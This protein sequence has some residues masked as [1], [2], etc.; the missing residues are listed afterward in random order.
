MGRRP[1]HPTQPRPDDEPSFPPQ[2]KGSLRGDEIHC[3]DGRLRGSLQPTALEGRGRSVDRHDL[4]EVKAHS[5]PTGLSD[6]QPLGDLV[7]TMI[8]LIVG[9]PDV[10][11]LCSHEKD[12]DVFSWNTGRIREVFGDVFRSHPDVVDF[13]REEMAFANSKIK[14]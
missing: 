2:I 10:E 11:F 5:L 1:H 4:Q 12:N 8:T 7:E 6:R 13:I 3:S 14:N 9:N